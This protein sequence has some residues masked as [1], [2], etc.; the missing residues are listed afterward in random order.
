MATI[1]GLTAERM[2]AIEAASVVDGEV[3]GDNLIL[4]RFDDSTIDAGNV[5]GA[6]GSPGLTEEEF[7]AQVTP[8]G[9]IVDFINTT[10]PTNWLAMIGQTIVGGESTYPLFWAAIPAAMKS[11]SNILMPDTRGRVSVGYHSGNTKFDTILETGGAETHTLTQAQLPASSITIDP[12]NT[13]VSITDPGHNHTQASHN[14]TQNAHNHGTTEAAHI[15]YQD[16]H[17]HGVEDPAGGAGSLPG[18]VTQSSGAG[19]QA[20]QLIAGSNSIA[21]QTAGH[22]VEPI[23]NPASTGLTINNATATN[24]AA[25]A[26]NVANTTGITASVNIASFSSGVLGSGESHNI[27]QPYIT[28]LK[29]VKVA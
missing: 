28:F 29:I 17:A 20:F 2:E 15:H 12:P 24:I 9:S 1:T 6:T 19:S 22:V 3:V 23:I 16:G 27:I 4:T 14:H 18:Y 8:V 7:E 25:T 21:T 10:A 5:R 26:T 11:G 13:A